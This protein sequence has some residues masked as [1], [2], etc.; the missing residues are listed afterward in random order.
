MMKELFGCVYV[1]ACIGAI[2]G[3]AYMVFKFFVW[4]VS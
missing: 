2:V 1:G 4:I 3:S